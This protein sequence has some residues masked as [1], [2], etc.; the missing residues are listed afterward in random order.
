M[1]RLKKEATKVLKP[2]NDADLEVD[3]DD[4][5]K[6]SSVLDMPIRP[7][8]TYEMTKEQLDEQEK[9]Y[10]NV[11]LKCYRSLSLN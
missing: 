5:Y 9:K 11:I 2:L 8:W 3:I 1:K 10:F 6:P 4:V 7:A